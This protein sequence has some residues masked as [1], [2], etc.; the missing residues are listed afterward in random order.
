MRYIGSKTLLL[1]QIE[2]VIRENINIPP[3]IFCDIFSGTASVARHFKKYHQIISNDLLHFS[4]ALQVGSLQNNSQPSFQKLK[5]ILINDPL[6][7]LNSANISK[8]AFKQAP[9]IFENFSPND[10]SERQYLSND[11][12]LRIDYIRQTIEDWNSRDLITSGEYYYLLAALIEAIPFVSNIAGTYGAYL[13]HWDKR[14]HKKLVM[15][16]LA[17]IDNNKNNQ[18]FNIDSNELIKDIEGDILY[19]DPPY[20]SR[21]YL[22]N[23]HLLETVSRYDSPPLKGKTGLRPYDDAK[24]KYC[25]QATV[26][27]AFRD[28]IKSAR[29][30][31]IVVSYSSE[32]L[33]PEAEIESALKE[34]GVESTYKLYRLPY[35]RYKR[36]SNHVDHS[37]EEFL[38]YIQK[39]I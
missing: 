19:I 39:S 38:F 26:H 28:L 2:N 34:Y 37:L 17:I 22:P 29:F 30:K 24:S 13:K 4:Y 31:H 7:Y 20:N 3:G 10:K 11:N 25:A 15:E 8:D 14:A 36:T 12:A 16:R 27:N 21:Q 23:Y 33:M 6:V 5:Q 1:D 32:G 18:C 9:F 35:R